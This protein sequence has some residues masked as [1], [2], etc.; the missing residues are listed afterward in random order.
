MSN[1]NIKTFLLPWLVSL[2]FSVC[3]IGILALVFPMDKLW[4]PALP[5]FSGS[6][7]SAVGYNVYELYQRFGINIKCFV[8]FAILL[9]VFVYLVVLLLKNNI[10]LF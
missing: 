10:C 6:F 9:S 8:V 2:S 1:S 5:I 3:A 4:I 7:V